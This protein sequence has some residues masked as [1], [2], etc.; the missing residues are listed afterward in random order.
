LLLCKSIIER[1]H[2]K[3][4]TMGI[5]YTV[6]HGCTT[7]T[8]YTLQKPWRLLNCHS[9]ETVIHM[10]RNTLVDNKRTPQRPRKALLEMM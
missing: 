3:R 10:E 6:K 1:M 9:H 7:G 5:F 8:L 2:D 4:S